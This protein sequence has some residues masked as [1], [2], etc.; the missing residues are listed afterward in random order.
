MRGARPSA[1]R[2]PSG[3]SRRTAPATPTGDE[4]EL[5]ALGKFFGAPDGARAANLG[6]V[7][8]MIGHAMPAAGIAG[9]IKAAL[10]IHRGVVPPS[11]HCDEPHEALARTRFRVPD[12][13]EPWDEL[14]RRAGVSAFGFGGINAHV[15]L[16]EHGIEAAARRAASGR[17]VR[18]TAI[19]TGV[20]TVIDAATVA[21]TVGANIA[22]WAIEPGPAP[23]SSS[24]LRV[25]RVAGD[26]IDALRAGLDVDAPPARGAMRLALLDPTP[27]RLALARKALDRGK[28][29]RGS[30]DLWL[31]LAPLGGKVAFVFPG[32]EAVF[33]PDVSELG[34]DVPPELADA[35]TDDDLEARGKGVVALG[36]LLATRGSA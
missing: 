3:S 8:S 17:T 34:D 32:V 23:A 27:E 4:V 11:L 20:H 12:R 15:V 21:A 36:R 26:S 19:G 10:A 5:E 35:I 9:L 13:A 28:P 7:K 30:H 22:R 14:P 2:R 1:I 33:A 29:V 25:L 6:S 24:K 18:P 31:S 16:E